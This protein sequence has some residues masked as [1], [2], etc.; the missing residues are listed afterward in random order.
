MASLILGF[1]F[2]INLSNGE[3]GEKEGTKQSPGVF[4]KKS[5]LKIS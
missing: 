4:Y 2:S 1:I 3:K 5:F